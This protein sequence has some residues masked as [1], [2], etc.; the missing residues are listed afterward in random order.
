MEAVCRTRAEAAGAFLRDQ[1]T[2]EQAK[3][4]KRALAIY[5]NPGW[6]LRVLFVEGTNGES[7]EAAEIND[8]VRARTLGRATPNRWKPAASRRRGRRGAPISRFPTFPLAGSTDD[9]AS[10]PA[11]SRRP[12]TLLFPLRR[13]AI[14]FDLHKSLPH[15]NFVATIHHG[16]PPDLLRPSSEPGR[17][18]AFLGRISPEK[19]PDRAI[20]IAGAAGI[21][22][23]VA[24]KVDTVD[25]DYFRKEILPRKLA[26]G[27]PNY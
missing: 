11:G 16:I 5:R 10:R 2:S 23:K 1:T 9:H 4:L 22:L 25:E 12:R 27:R 15:A 20:R 21:P 6:R 19:R 8:L 14:D 7:V 13:N 18:L 26:A 17:Y 3:R 24:A